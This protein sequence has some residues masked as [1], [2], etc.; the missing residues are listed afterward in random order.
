MRTARSALLISS[1]L[2][3]A[4]GGAQATP[5]AE[6]PLAEAP[7]PAAEPAK[8]SEPAKPAAS[9][10][11]GA[12]EAPPPVAKGEP[13]PN[14]TREVTYVVVPEGLKV[15]VAGVRFAVS[16]SAAQVASGWG[17]KLNVVASAIDGKPHSLASPK[18]GPLAFAGAVL[19]KGQSEAEPFGD[20]RSGDGEQSIFGDDPTKFSRT[21]PAKGVRALGAGDSL[22]LQVALWGLGTERDS[23]RPVKKFCH[24][25]MQVGKG[26]PR[27]ILEPPQGLSSK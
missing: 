13:D 19:R 25:R 2:A 17:V 23:R 5:P 14:A 8:P 9:D 3:A 16:A 15:S 22:D 27:A 7:T 24:L 21:W 12:T 10:A 18:T 11:A 20:E 1:L 26:K 4:C 6:P